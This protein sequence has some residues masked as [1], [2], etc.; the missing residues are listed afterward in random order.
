MKDKFYLIEK[1]DVI[2]CDESN[3]FEPTEDDVSDNGLMTYEEICLFRNS[4]R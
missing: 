4:G 1:D 3:V 2:I